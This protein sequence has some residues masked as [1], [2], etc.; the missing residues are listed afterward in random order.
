MIAEPFCNVCRDSRCTEI[1]AFKS[2]LDGNF[3]HVI[4]CKRCGLLFVSPLPDLNPEN[5]K[6]IYSD[7]YADKVYPISETT[8]VEDAL[9]RQMD[10]VEPYGRIGD[11]LNVGAMSGECRILTERGWKLHTVDASAYA[12][13]RARKR[14][15][16]EVTVS[17]IEDFSPPPESYDFIKL[18]HVIEHLGDPSATLEHLHP[19]LRDGGLI[20]IDTDN[21]AGLETRAE[22][23][24]TGL[25]RM[26]PVRRLAEGL[27]GKKYNLR[28]GRL[29]PPVHLYTFTMRSLTSLVKQKG[30]EVVKTFNAAWG[31]PTWFPLPSKSILERAFVQ[32]DRIGVKFGY[33]NVIA[34]LARKV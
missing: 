21:A 27:A 22:A 2:D 20:L 15:G 34:V 30:F 33:G 4:K 26:K 6:K 19:M 31:D 29:T 12:A 32:I 25:M 3:Y 11:I 23:T 14:W 5:V 16:F 24:I 17:R 1:T 9:R 28:Y 10:I 7:E 18:G 8:M 13:E